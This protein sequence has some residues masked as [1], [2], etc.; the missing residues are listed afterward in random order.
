LNTES[1]GWKKQRDKK[2]KNIANDIPDL[3]VDGDQSGELL[4]LGWGGTYG[5]IAEAVIKSRKDGYTVSQAHLKYLNPFPR[6]TADVLKRFKTVLIPE[7]NLGQLSKIIRSEFLIDVKQLNIV[8]GL[9]LRVTDIEDKIIE[10]AKS[11][12]GGK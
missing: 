6:N 5:A 8:R 3:I 11:E 2:I 1:A 7:I 12:Q 9:P 10:L 4:V